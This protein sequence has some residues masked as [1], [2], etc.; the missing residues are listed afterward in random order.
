[1]VASLGPARIPHTTPAI[2][3]NGRIS[4]NGPKINVL[5]M[6]RISTDGNDRIAKPIRI[7]NKTDH[8]L[9]VNRKLSLLL[10]HA[11]DGFVLLAEFRNWR[12]DCG[13]GNGSHWKRS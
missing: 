9:I 10:Q 8:G 6:L 11:P 13:N 7:T 3:T 5:V 1:M 12:R 2:A 4:V